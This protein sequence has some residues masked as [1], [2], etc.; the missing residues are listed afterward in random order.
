[1]RVAPAIELNQ[2]EEAELS[3][4]AQSKLSFVRLAERARIVLL[5]AQGLQNLQIAQ[6]LCVDQITA[7]C[8][9]QRYIESGLAGIERDLPRGWPPVK[10]GVAKLVELTTQTQPEA[11]MHWSTRT[12]AAVL[13]VSPSAAMRYWQ[14]SGLK[15]R[16]VRGFKISRDPRLVEKL[17]DIV[18][19]STTLVF[20]IIVYCRA[21]M[22]MVLRG[23]Y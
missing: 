19:L 21:I 17:E 14:A 16:L 23:H 1:M 12:M 10:V 7:G 20:P 9:R 22:S 5:A 18:G 6:E 8:W 15:P 2:E 4:L 13:E 11:A 3:R